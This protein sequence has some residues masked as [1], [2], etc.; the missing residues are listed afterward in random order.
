VS[1]G[2]KSEKRDFGYLCRVKKS[3]PRGPD[4]SGLLEIDGVRYQLSGWVRISKKGNKYLSLSTTKLDA[5]GK[6]IL[7]RRGGGA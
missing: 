6:P 1:N 2:L 3:N 4:M 5:D 7:A